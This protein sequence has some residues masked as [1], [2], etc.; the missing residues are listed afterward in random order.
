MDWHPER[1][2][3][4]ELD[5]LHDVVSYLG[6]ADSVLE[7]DVQVDDDSLLQDAHLHSSTNALALKDL[8]QTTAE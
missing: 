1:S 3:D 2:F 6:D 4:A 7:N 5:V 8:S